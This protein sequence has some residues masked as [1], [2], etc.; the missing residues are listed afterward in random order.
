M[1]GPE[2]E[3]LEF[4][5]PLI[6]LK[7]S[8]FEVEAVAPEKTVY[9]GKHG[10]KAEPQRIIDEAKVED[11]EVLIIPGGWAP[12]RLRRNQ[13]VVE[14]VKAFFNSGKTVAAICHGPQLLISAKVIK[15]FRLTSSSA[16]KDDVENAGGIYEDKPV[17][18]DRNLI[19]SRGPADLHLFMKAVVGRLGVR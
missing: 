15:G 1:L 12:D 10:I 5:Y 17:V 14:F 4:F 8:G 16:V 2:F 7:E 6:R 9:T 19:T 13:K 11:Y 3:D 18:Q